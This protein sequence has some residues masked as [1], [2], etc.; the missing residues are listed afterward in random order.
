MSK[1]FT[2]FLIIVMAA[3]AQSTVTDPRITSWLTDASGSY[4]RL[5]ESDANKLAGT[6]SL[7]WSRGAGVQ[8]SPVYAGVTQVQFSANSV[9]L[10]TTGLGY[11]IMGPWY[12][13]VAHTQN[14]GNFPA[15]QNALFQLPRTPVVPLAKTLTNAGPIGVGVD[16]VALFDNRDTFSYA[17]SSAQ[18]G[19]PMNGLRGDGIWNRDAYIN[20]GMTFDPAF[21]HQA[22]SIYHYHA[23]TPALRFLLGDH[24]NFDAVTKAYTE[25]TSPVTKHSPILAWLSD[26]HPV[27]GPYGYASA[28]NA[29]SG[30]RRMV[31]G[32]IKRDG[33]NGT[34]NL[35][36]TGRTTLPPW[37]AL[38]QNRSA[39][40]ATNQQGPVVSATYILGHYLEDYDYLGNL[41]KL[42]GVDYDLDQYNGRFC[43]TPEFPNGT[44]AYFITI[45]ADGTP[46]FPYIIGRWFYG[47]PTGKV[48]TSISETV[49]EYD[50]GA[51]TAA[52]TLTG[53]TS[54]NGVSL[55]WNSVEGATYK[56]EASSGGTTYTTLASA[57][58]SSGNATTYVA[59]TKE[60]YYRVTLTAIAVYDTNGPIGMPVGTTVTLSYL[61]S[62]S[63]ATGAVSAASTTPTS[64]TPTTPTAPT[65]PP[66]MPAPTV[67]TTPAASSG[68]G[69]GAPSWWFGGL[70]A[71][72]GFLRRR[73]RSA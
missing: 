8:S 25:S 63:T 44:Y 36:A 37:A 71:L 67:T 62:G 45:E 49:T 42:Q 69:G 19:N 29:A 40:L 16:G 56:V 6:A 59:T 52:I 26:G 46:K 18:D 53:T 32:Y 24:V 48:V 55:I 73:V 35:T 38:A 72:L 9:Y 30:L 66:P 20:E 61:A 64:T 1:F 51:P 47:S 12:G 54:G 22:G 43:V 50:R 5:Y 39:T 2:L 57:L 28:L 3:W 7:T 33:T 4:A 65:T 34:T 11:H 13:N 14:F 31:P 15:N 41:G 23:N 10:R 58:T 68:G 17:N 60:N 27:Y 70:L 21:A